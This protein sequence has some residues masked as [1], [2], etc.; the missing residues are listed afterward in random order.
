MET[1][2]LTHHGVKGMKWGVR[3][4]QTLTRTGTKRSSK[5][6]IGML[7]TL[8]KTRVSTIGKKVVGE[9]REDI[10]SLTNKDLRERVER[11]KLNKEYEKLTRSSIE[12][13]AARLSR[14]AAA[15]LLSLSVTAVTKIAK[16]NLDKVL[17]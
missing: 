15:S 6:F 2:A 11:L 10:S 14:A 7:D 13:G 3:K 8:Y 9:K 12:S 1:D 4:S 17:G 16:K 5:R